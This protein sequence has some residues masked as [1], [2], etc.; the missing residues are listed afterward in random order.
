MRARGQLAAARVRV[1]ACACFACL[2]ACAHRRASPWPA[3][4]LQAA[5]LPQTCAKPHQGACHAGV[6]AEAHVRE[7]ARAGEGRL[8]VLPGSP[9]TAVSAF[10]A[11]QRLMLMASCF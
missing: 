4:T 1:V 2:Q 9:P 11:R 7:P 6:E 5:L 3:L 8:C 10:N